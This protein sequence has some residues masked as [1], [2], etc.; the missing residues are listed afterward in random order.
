MKTKKSILKAIVLVTILGMAMSCELNTGK[1][2]SPIEELSSEIGPN[3][4]GLSDESKT[5]SEPVFM[6]VENQ[7]TPMGGMETF[8]EY[9]QKN[10]KYPEQARKLGIEGKVFVEIIVG[11]DGKL[12]HV[13]AVKGIGG[14]CDEEAVRVISNS[15][16]WQPGLQDGKAVNV[17]MMLPITFK[18]G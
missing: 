9:I 3:S 7:P 2:T 1:E 10:L 13:K 4:T 14:G 16:K 8:F 12:T 15:P 17:K 11:P 6:I 5:D 18:L